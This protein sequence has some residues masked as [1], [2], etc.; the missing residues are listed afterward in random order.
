MISNSI[1][2]VCLL[3][4]S[5]PSFILIVHLVCLFMKQ[6]T[7]S[8]PLHIMDNPQTTRVVLHLRDYIQIANGT[9]VTDEY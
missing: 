7:A 8:E 9:L 1:S 3:Q 2:C 6:T 5:N 4:L